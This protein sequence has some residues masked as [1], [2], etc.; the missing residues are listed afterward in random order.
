[1]KKVAKASIFVS[2][3]IF[4][5]SFCFAQGLDVQKCT[6]NGKKLYGNIKVVD[7]FP[8]VRV[9]IVNIFSDLDVQVVSIL[10]NRCGQWR[11][12]DSFPDT[13]VKFV[14]LFGDVKVRYVDYFPGMK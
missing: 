2:L 10:P 9:Q 4:T 14:N 3:F 8:D 11:F 1:M 6:F 5:V 7:S 12:V 13:R